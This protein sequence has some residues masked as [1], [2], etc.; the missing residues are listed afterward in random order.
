MRFSPC[1]LSSSSRRRRRSLASRA[2]TRSAFGVR[3]ARTCSD[4][5]IGC[6]SRT[7]ETPGLHV[8]SAPS[9]AQNA[10][11]RLLN[12]LQVLYWRWNRAYH[13]ANNRIVSRSHP[14]KRG[15]HSGCSRT[16]AFRAPHA[17]SANAPSTRMHVATRLQV[18]VALRLVHDFLHLGAGLVRDLVLV[19]QVRGF[20]DGLGADIASGIH[21][22]SDLGLEIDLVAEVGHGGLRLVESLLH[23][24]EHLQRFFFFPPISGARR[25]AEEKSRPLAA[26]GSIAPAPWH[27]RCPFP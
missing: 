17:F 20:L 13:A 1:R 9:A 19:V 4:V 7:L 15:R 16:P 25:R 8:R 27:L 12:I 18:G 6:R 3:F 5:G 2:R 14:S 26:T 23:L 24:G 21:E 10:S 11:L 22:L